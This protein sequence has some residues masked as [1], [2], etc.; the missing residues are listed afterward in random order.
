LANG[1][2]HGA[3][4]YEI[5]STTLKSEKANQVD[6]TNEFHG[7]HLSIVVNPFASLLTDYVYLNPT[8]SL[9][10]SLPVFEY[11][12]IDKA[13]SYGIDLG[14]HYHPHFAHWLHLENSFSHVAI[15]GRDG[16]NVA[17]IPQT[18]ISTLVK[19]SFEMKTKVRL[20]QFTVQH[21]YYFKQDRI[22][23]FETPSPAYQVVNLG[24]QGKITGKVPLEIKMGVK[25]LLNAR[26]IDHLSRLK[27]IDLPFPG[28]N[29]YIS[30]NYQIIY[31]SKSKSK[32]NEK[33]N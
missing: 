26:Y 31:K 33:V 19:A 17:L 18:R 11:K 6:V 29:Y 28:R 20:E 21:I 8:D 4:R 16:F 32:S 12:Q 24:L 22:A 3:L 1:F 15:E 30:L 10:E 27:N 13:Y 25:N 14:W 2:H 5:G 9:I 23:A 7:E